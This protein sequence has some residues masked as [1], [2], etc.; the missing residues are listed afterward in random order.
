MT[1]TNCTVADNRATGTGGGIAYICAG[2]VTV[3]NSIAWNNT[4]TSG[5]GHHVYKI[6]G[7][8][9]VGTITYSDFELNNDYDTYYQGCTVTDGGNNVHPAEDPSFG[10]NYRLTGFSINVIDEALAADGPSDDI[11]GDSR[12]PVS[13][14]IDMG[15]DEYIP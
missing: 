8:G 3:K 11:D 12:I 14:M 5:N 13:G 6:C 2:T 9:N 7:S 4:A 15:A 1:L 10:S